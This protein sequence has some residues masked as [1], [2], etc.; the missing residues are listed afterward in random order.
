[1]EQTCLGLSGGLGP[2]KAP[3]FQGT[4]GRVV[5]VA[6]FDFEGCMTISWTAGWRQEIDHQTL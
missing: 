3:L 5:G 4:T 2:T 1:M 6:A